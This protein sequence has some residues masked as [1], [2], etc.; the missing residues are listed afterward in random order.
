MSNVLM[1]AIKEISKEKGISVESV[2]KSIELA[3]ASAYRKDFGEKNQNLKAEF[4]P[5]T[6]QTRIFDIKKVVTGPQEDEEEINPKTEILLEEAQKIKPGIK[7]EEEIKTELEIPSAYGRVAAQT[8]KQVIIQKLREEERQ[9]VYEEFKQKE[10]QL[11][12]G[13]VQRVERKTVLVDLNRT[14]GIIPYEEQIRRERYNPGQK[15]KVLILKV[16][17]NT[18]GPQ[19]ILSRS[20]PDII[21]QLFKMEV[22]EINA[23]TVEI[24]GVAR[25]AG[26]RSKI[27]VLAKDESIDP[28]G[29]CIGQRGSRV[30]T[31]I[32][33]LG[34]EKID[35][36]EYNEDSVKFITNALSPAK[37]S[38]IDIKEEEKTAY[39]E[40][41]SD[42]LSLAIGR[43]GQNVR[44]ASKL[45]DWKIE[46]KEIKEDGE[47]REVKE[48]EL[49]ETENQSV[50]E[51][52]E[53][54]TPEKN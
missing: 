15:I 44:L 24:K 29:A 51:E 40:V 28:I 37:L 10:G 5:E 39:I 31:I 48:D 30:Q 13:V 47:T 23:G 46:L 16:E 27:A 18:R 1:D 32:Q 33:E 12:T 9:T 43:F 2:I 53:E 34:G 4:N 6:G 50:N 3:L 21:A 49:K 11:I 25:E 19:I 26:E 41:A 8:A 42:Q 54:E 22:P 7:E 45:T 17:E 52:T 38:S 14:T 35:I 20:H 36:V